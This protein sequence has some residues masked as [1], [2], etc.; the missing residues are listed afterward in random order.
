MIATH[1]NLSRKSWVQWQQEVLQLLEQE[2]GEALGQVRLSDVDWY[3]WR[4]LFDEGRNARAA[5][6][7][8]LERDF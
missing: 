1:T 3:A 7:R 6:D 4:P 2:L 5:I 8:A